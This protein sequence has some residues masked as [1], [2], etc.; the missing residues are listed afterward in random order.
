M[1]YNEDY[2]INLMD[3]KNSNNVQEC[4]FDIGYNIN[5]EG[6][7]LSYDINNNLE[8]MINLLNN[9]K[10]GN[11]DTELKKSGNDIDIDEEY[12]NKEYLKPLKERINKKKI[13]SL[14]N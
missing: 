6:N 8:D 1:N 9:V 7:N 4:D 5:D 12:I 3:I 13:E 14:F 2:N 11:K 10:I